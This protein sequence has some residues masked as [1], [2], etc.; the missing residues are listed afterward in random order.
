MNLL[1]CLDFDNTMSTTSLSHDKEYNK[2]HIIKKSHISKLI[3][4][5]YLNK[6]NQNH[7]IIFVI[8]SY[9]YRK[10]IEDFIKYTKL[11]K[12]FKDIITPSDYNL[13]EGFHYAKELDG[14]NK[15]LFD[16]M[17]K[18]DVE[19]HNVL[20]IDDNKQIIKRAKKYFNTIYVDSEKGL[21]NSYK[22]RINNFIKD[23]NFT[24]HF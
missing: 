13:E 18:Y 2:N 5:N 17:K 11:T 3:N 16:L 15:M 9:G 22:D 20:L 6:L 12:I 23:R 14:K 4:S 8:T 10:V 24:L 7:N 1:I 21:T 19:S